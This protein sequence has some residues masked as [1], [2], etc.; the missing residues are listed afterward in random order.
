MDT[1]EQILNEVRSV[2][3][4][5][6]STHDDLAKVKSQIDEMQAKGG[7]MTDDLRRDFDTRMTDLNVLK[8]RMDEL[9]QKGAESSKRAAGTKSWG[10]QLVEHDGYDGFQKSSA[11]GRTS[12]RANIKATVTTTL[13]G[14]GGS[15]TGLLAPAYRD[16]ELVRMERTELTI[17]DLL[18]VINVDSGS[19]DF[20]R[21]TTRNNA[22]APVAETEAKPYSDYGW[23]SATVNV[24]TLAHLTKLSRQAIDDAPRLVG[25]VDSEMRYGL[26]LVKEQQ[27]L[28][29][30]GTGQ[31]LHGLMPQATAFALPTGVTNASVKFANRVDV[32]RMAML[33]LQLAGAPVDG[34]VLNPLDWAL[35]ELTKDENG[36]YAFSRPDAGLRSPGMWGTPI[37]STSAMLV[38]DFLIGSFKTGATAYKRMGVEVLI[39]TENDKDFEQNLATMRAEERV[40]LAVKRAYAFQKGK[41]STAVGLL[42]A[43][44]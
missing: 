43:T 32:L 12:F 6:K 4:Q 15:G 31:N 20:A 2:A 7:K 38:D 23:E 27:Y 24:R 29:G 44:P 41:F 1:P 42:T 34:M 35:I 26:G 13:A 19:V 37:I 18:T 25:E 9:E 40:A 39:S 28:Y 3:A 21:Q 30:N 33:N 5:F 11:S 17:E 8:A 16:G 10:E 14:A 22:A 36:G